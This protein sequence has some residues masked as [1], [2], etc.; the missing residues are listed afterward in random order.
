M[1]A[2]E[3]NVNE[4]FK[5]T[6]KKLAKKI[7]EAEHRKDMPDEA[8]V[9]T[10]TN[11]IVFWGNEM[12]RKRFKRKWMSQQA[13]TMSGEMKYNFNKIGTVCSVQP[14]NNG[15]GEIWNIWDTADVHMT[16]QARQRVES[17][18]SESALKKQEEVKKEVRE[19]EQK[20]SEKSKS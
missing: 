8:V 19:M 11:S 20:E 1:Q 2:H 9:V 5:D 15:K 17:N 7:G 6:Q 16:K 14:I 4:I 18:A 13:A 3:E 12:E 10:I